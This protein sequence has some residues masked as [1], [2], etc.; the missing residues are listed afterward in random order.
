MSELKTGLVKIGFLI[1]V[2]GLV[3]LGCSEKNSP[4]NQETG[5]END[6][7]AQEEAKGDPSVPLLIPCEV[8]GKPVSKKS[9]KCLQHVF[10]LSFKTHALPR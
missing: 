6:E 8:C 7:G 4:S 5:V 10:S 1:G 9:E 2:C 3:T